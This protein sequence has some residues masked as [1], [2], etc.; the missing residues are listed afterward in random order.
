MPTKDEELWSKIY[1]YQ[2]QFNKFIEKKANDSKMV[3]VLDTLLVVDVY[4]AMAL[5]LAPKCP[6]DFKAQVD[7]L[8]SILDRIFDYLHSASYDKETDEKLNNEILARMDRFFEFL[9]WCAGLEVKIPDNADQPMGKGC[10]MNFIIA[11]PLPQV[12]VP[13]SPPSPKAIEQAQELAKAI[14]TYHSQLIEYILQKANRDIFI[15]VALMG[16]ETAYL[17]NALG[18]LLMSLCPW[19][20]TGEDLESTAEIIKHMV[21]TVNSAYDA[22][23]PKEEVMAEIALR[24]QEYI[25]WREGFL[26][27]MAWCYDIDMDVE[28][29]PKGNGMEITIMRY[30]PAPPQAPPPQGSLGAPAN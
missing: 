30:E 16:F 7:A 15:P 4:Q 6:E 18:V 23:R 27:R 20:F 24:A 21:S 26:M 22:K 29:I 10:K 19:F 11:K 17:Y 25:V 1:A 5:V 28:F 2:D 12:P 9:A 13:P 8:K 3:L 14:E